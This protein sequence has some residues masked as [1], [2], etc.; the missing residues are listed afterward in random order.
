MQ[1]SRVIDIVN[2]QN[3]WRRDECLN[4]IAS[5]SLMS[6]LAESLYASDFEGRYNEHE[7]PVCHYEGTQLSYEIEEG[8]NQLFR[9]RFQTPY[10]DVRPISGAIANLIIYSALTRVGDLIV[11]LGIPNGAHI[12]HTRWGP[13]GVRGLKNVDMIF[14]AENMNIDAERT[15]EIIKVADPKLVMFGAS[16]FL[17]PE[18]VKEIKEMID[19]DIKII[20][21][22][23]HVFG[24]VYNG[25]FQ[26]PLK[27]G[28]DFITSST[29]K[30]FQGP[31]GGMIIGEPN[32][33]ERDW[34]RVDKAVFPGMLSNTHIHRFPSLAITALEMNQYGTEYAKQVVK[35]AKAFGR[36]LD[37]RGFNVLC[38]HL[39]YTE[40]HQVIVNV[41]Q[42]GGG[43]K[44]AKTLAECNI[45]CNKIAIPSDTSYDATHNPSGI[46]LGVQELTRWG[47]KE[48]EMDTVAELYKN[49][50][51][52]KDP[53]EKV[54]QAAKEFKQ[55]YP[56][57]HYCT[58]HP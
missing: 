39:G 41:S 21:D 35:N 55:Q 45:I 32:L 12:S 47:M 36:A 34:A 37:D 6:P 2:Q 53:V 30:T 38:P 27:E 50:I 11:S 17:F 57:I 49:A 23:A 15:A 29:H 24:L 33:S 8:C 13:A 7:G 52:D 16:M 28:A 26:N 5:E 1:K 3:R 14:D 20:Y 18:P 19:P 44:V 22:A 43:E 48:K 56:N 51:M 58:P 25:V 46:R 54:K 9:D 40:S 10:V 4:L 31:Q 42:R